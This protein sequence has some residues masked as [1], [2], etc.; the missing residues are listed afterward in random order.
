MKTSLLGV[1]CS[2]SGGLMKAFEEAKRLD[3]DTF[4]IFTQN[5]RQWINKTIDPEQRK[6]FADAWK[7]SKVK[8]VFS[9]C[10]YL[11]N[12]ASED[13][14]L[15]KK[16]TEAL[17]G[18]IN[19]CHD[20]N[21]SFCVLHPGA[22]KSQNP[23][24]AIQ[25]VIDG[26]EHVVKKTDPSKVKIL[27][28]NT[29]GQ[30]SSLGHSFEQLGRIVSG[31]ASSRIGVC[32]DT[33]HAFA[34][35]YDLRTKSTFEQTLSDFDKIIGIKH[36]SAIHLNDS[37]GDLGCRTDRHEHI[38]KGKLGLEAFRLA[39]KHFEKLPKVLETEKENGMD[40]VNL[41]VLRRM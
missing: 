3:I 19:R 30:G 27:V 37:K 12:L 36:L 16:S 38:G 20:L 25:H 41:Q 7:S 11:L 32:F 24:V 35:G 28:E 21:L 13:N 29:A 14:V 33:C 4:Q 6:L 18:E 26:L 40:E 10:S 2:V 5:Q 31:V 34:A 8:V 23:D 22:A 39:L 9:H 15:R 1:H 17:I